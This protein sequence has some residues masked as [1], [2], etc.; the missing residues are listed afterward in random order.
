M[1]WRRR[2][3]CTPNAKASPMGR[4]SRSGMPRRTPRYA[5]SKPQRN[6][7]VDGLRPADYHSLTGTQMVPLK[8]SVEARMANLESSL[9]KP[10]YRAS[11][12]MR[13][14]WACGR[15]YAGAVTVRARLSASTGVVIRAHICACVCVR[16]SKLMCAFARVPA[17]EC[18]CVHACVRGRGCVRDS[19]FSVCIFLMGRMSANESARS[20][21][22]DTRSECQAA[23]RHRESTW[24]GARV[25]LWR[26]QTSAA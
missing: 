5:S 24:V 25:T 1:R 21:S 26:D 17:F 22:R 6:C 14:A 10:I 13:A 23:A 4:S 15:A 2:L 18:A 19:C 8:L 20:F 9:G 3:C 16:V 12:C 7:V 11:P